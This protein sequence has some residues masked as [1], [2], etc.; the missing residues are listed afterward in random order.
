MAQITD[1][2]SFMAFWQTQI[3]QSNTSIQTFVD[4]TED[5]PLDGFKSPGITTP[6]LVVFAPEF[7]TIDQRSDNVQRNIR[8]GFWVV[9]KATK[10]HDRAEIK[11]LK[12]DCL[13]IVE[14]IIGRLGY[15]NEEKQYF[16]QYWADSTEYDEIGPVFDN[17]YGYQCF[18]S[19]KSFSAI[20]HDPT[21]WT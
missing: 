19:F 3:A 7:R 2:D 5:E 11:Q 6:A 17:H 12:N 20:K 18:G 10:K 13:A 1:R 8:F 4:A 15:L 21:K 14:Q 9:K 16:G